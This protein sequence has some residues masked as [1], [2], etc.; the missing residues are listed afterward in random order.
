MIL[1][2][3]DHSTLASEL[4][5]DAVRILA[6]VPRSKR[7][8]DIAL[9]LLGLP[10]ALPVI[11][12]IIILQKLTTRG[13]IFFRQHRV[14]Q[15]GRVFSMLK[16]RSMHVDA[17]ARLAEVRQDSNRNGICFKHK[18][19]PR[20]TMLGRFLRRSSLDE[21]PQ[22]WNVLRGEMS[23]VGPRPAL[24]QEVAEYPDHAMGRLAG[25]PGLTGLWQISGRA[26]LDFDQMVE[27]DLLY[28]QNVSV[29][30][31]LRILMGTFGAV[32]TGR[33]AY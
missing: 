5:K 15:N 16:F 7:V 33:G 27:L 32:F 17:E 9:L 2:T 13:P 31:D 6:K 10:L 24:P 4:P 30:T 1:M 21:L 14:G 23:L 19:D 26:D 11:L 25:L 8:L 12:T 22:L 29:A 28:L 20:V 18:D 3:P